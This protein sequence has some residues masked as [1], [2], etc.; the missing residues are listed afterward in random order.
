MLNFLCEH[1]CG[2]CLAVSVKV[3]KDSTSIK[4]AFKQWYQLLKLPMF[5]M[6]V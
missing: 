2:F 3:H 4:F 6:Q 1:L 5:A